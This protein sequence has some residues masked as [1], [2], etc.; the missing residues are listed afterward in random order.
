[1]IFKMARDRTEDV[2]DVKRGAVI[3]DN[4]GR[5]SSQKVRKC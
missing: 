3:K 5:G 2:R 1:M 4:N